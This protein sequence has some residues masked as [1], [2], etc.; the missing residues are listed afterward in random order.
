MLP[1]RVFLLLLLTSAPALAEEEIRIA[2]ARVAGPA[3]VSGTDLRVEDIVTGEILTTGKRVVIV[4]ADERGLTVAGKP[5]KARRVVVMGRDGVAYQG[6]SFRGRMEVLWERVKGRAQ[7]LLV[8]P[9]PMENYLVGILAGE[10]PSS[11]PPEAMKAQAVAARTYAIYQ[12]F[13][14]PDRPYHLESTVLDQVY[15]GIQRETQ[16]ARAAVAA[17]AGQVLTYRRRPIRAYFHSCCGDRTEGAR[18]GWGT[19]EPYLQSVTCGYCR[20]CGR[21]RWKLNVGAPALSRALDAARLPVGEVKTISVL[22]LTETGRVAQ[23]EVEGTQKTRRMHPEDLRRILGYEQLRSRLFTVRR[24]GAEFIFD[25]K[26]SGH[27]VGL[28]QWGARG[29]AHQKKDYRAILNHYYPGAR[30]Q[31]MY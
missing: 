19:S 17:T 18:D 22:K 4:G 16:Q 31:R 20:D 7:V 23:L 25:G 26:G 5:T 9:L 3:A 28:C 30:V 15:G 12:K 14:A 21:Y 2:V 29:M 11:W 10:L 8:H 1:R 24:D 13:H 6:R 27:A